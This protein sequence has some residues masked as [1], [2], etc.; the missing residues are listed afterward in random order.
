MKAPLSPSPEVHRW[1]DSGWGKKPKPLQGKSP[2]LDWPMHGLPKTLH[3]DNGAD[4]RSVALSRGCERYGINLEYRPPG[5]P[6]F[7]GHIERFLGTLMRR[8]HGL[9]G[10][11]SSSPAKK[12][13]YRSEARA[14]MTMTDLER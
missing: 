6:H 5:R 13:R 1:C 14:T 11:T 7:G 12:G 3:L 10:T 9:P 2:A 4:F 8:I